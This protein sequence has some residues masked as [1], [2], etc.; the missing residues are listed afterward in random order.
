MMQ[1]G[2]VQLSSMQVEQTH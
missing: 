2:H 1:F